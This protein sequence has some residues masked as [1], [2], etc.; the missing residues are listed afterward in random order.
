MPDF[1]KEN[2]DAFQVLIDEK[3]IYLDYK[4]GS[5]YAFTHLAVCNK[6]I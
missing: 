1:F 4:F 6:L 2:L 5:Y 3:K